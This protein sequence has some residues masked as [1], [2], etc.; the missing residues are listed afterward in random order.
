[1]T[2]RATLFAWALA[3]ALAGCQSPAP[4]QRAESPAPTPP[5]LPPLAAQRIVCLGDS[6]TDGHTY[7]LLVQQALREAGRPVPVMIG[8]GAGGDNAAGMLA[9]LDRDVLAYQPDLV[10]LGTG[11]NDQRLTPAEYETALRALYDRLRAA[12]V[13]VL[14]LTLTVLAPRHAAAVPQLAAFDAVLRRLARE[15]GY[16]LADVQTL[17][18]RAAAAGVGLHEPDGV[19]LNLAGYQVLARAV[20]DALGHADVAVPE[21]FRPPLLPG[22]ITD[23]RLRPA[24]DQTPLT[25]ATLATLAPSR[26]W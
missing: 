15:Y 25:A 22:L 13:P 21:Q 12:R 1:M 14:V 5:G 24:P 3:V 18:A 10:A 8:A 17:Q 11:I 19:H 9:R 2:A 20:L 7:A 23:W 4:Q 26:A 16:R 6:I